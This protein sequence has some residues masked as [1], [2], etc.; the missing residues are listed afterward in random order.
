[1]R[2]VA[3]TGCQQEQP[4]IGSLHDLRADHNVVFPLILDI[5]SKFS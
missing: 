3:P 2:G 4:I 5:L 1:M